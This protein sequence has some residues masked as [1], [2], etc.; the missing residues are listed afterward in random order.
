MS[1]FL[2][3]PNDTA[4]PGASETSHGPGES[5]FLIG[6][7]ESDAAP[8]VSHAKRSGIVALAIAIACAG[9]GLFVMRTV[10][11]G[12]SVAL[13]DTEIDYT[14]QHGVAAVD[15]GKLIDDLQRSDS[16][17]QVPLRELP[18]NP[19][20]WN[21]VQR[22]EEPED[23]AFDEPQEDPSERMRR[24]RLREVEGAFALLTLNSVLS[25]PRP[26]VRISGETYT[27]GDVVEEIFVVESVDGRTVTLS[28]D[29]RSYELS[30]GQ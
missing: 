24:D 29:G 21:A 11:L 12:A 18:M 5:P 23:T 10:G 6:L 28:V 22:V 7:Q 26:V 14:V 1:N 2:D 13:A 16:V 20:A 25:G 9:G 27:I 3:D 17:V 30:I 15:H 19:F 8:A 4:D